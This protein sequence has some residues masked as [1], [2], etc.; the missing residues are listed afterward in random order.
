LDTLELRSTDKFLP[1][2]EEEKKREIKSSRYFDVTQA[3][4]IRDMLIIGIL[5]FIVIIVMAIIKNSGPISTGKIL[6]Y[7]VT[8]MIL[9]GMIKKLIKTIETVKNGA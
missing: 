1:L 8:T 6:F 4:Q 3:K 7:L 2:D 5:F 9:I